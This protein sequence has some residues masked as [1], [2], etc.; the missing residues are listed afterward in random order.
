VFQASLSLYTQDLYPIRRLRVITRLLSLDLAHPQEVSETL[1]N[2]LSLNRI[3]NISV[4]NTND[5]GLENYLVH[6]QTLTTTLLE[7]QQ[8]QP[9]I[10]VIKQCLAVWNSVRERCVDFTALEREI[11]D[12]PR[13]LAHL[14]LIADYM[15]MK[16]FDT[17]RVA[18]LR[19]IADFNQLRDDT[20]SPNDLVLS[21]TR[22]GTQWLQ[23]G[24]SG[25]AGLA[26]DRAHTYSHQNEVVPETLLQLHLSYS[27]YLLAIGNFDKRCAISFNT[28]SFLTSI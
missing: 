27:E 4:E 14:L 20:S 23:L 10:D 9:N 12:V 2:E 19:L 5:Q 17:I 21:F 8:E 15:E 6:F 22:L 26:L 13:L 1:S 3:R 11:E 7:L 28:L 16:G 24:Y 18:V 25:K